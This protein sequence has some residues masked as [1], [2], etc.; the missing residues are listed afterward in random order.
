M[1]RY[2]ARSASD[3]T[4]DWPFWFVA[5]LQKGGL[6]VTAELVREHVDPDH[7]G[8]VLCPE[9]VAKLIASWAN[10]LSQNATSSG[11][12]LEHSEVF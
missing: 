1:D 11:T 7:K 2:Y 3:R 8:G 10:L 12:R 9:S 4:D 6:N 5:D